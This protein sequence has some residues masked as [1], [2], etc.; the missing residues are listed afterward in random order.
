MSA[1]TATCERRRI[2]IVPGGAQER[3]DALPHPASL[4]ATVNENEICHQ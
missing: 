1:F 2:R 3:D 4:N